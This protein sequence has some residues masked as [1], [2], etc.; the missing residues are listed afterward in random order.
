MACDILG[1]W[2]ID[3]I[4]AIDMSFKQTWKSVS[5]LE[6]DA[7]IPDMQKT[8]AKSAFVF[9]QGGRLLQLMPAGLA[10]EGERFDDDYAVVHEGKWKE[11]DGKIFASSEENG[12]D[13]WSEVVPLDGRIEVFGFF[14]LS[15]CGGSAPGC[16]DIDVAGVWIVKEAMVFDEDL[17]RTW[18]TKEAAMADGSADED[19]LKTFDT[20][21]VFSDDGFV[22][23]VV[24]IPEGVTQEQ[25]DQAV[26]SGQ[27]DLYG[28][29]FM[30]LEKHPWKIEDGKLMIDTGA[31]GEV[32]GE[33][34][35]PWTEA[36]VVDGVMQ[37]VAYR[38]IKE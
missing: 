20:K 19:A 11:E 1:M 14:R 10:G 18:K 36:P 34:V 29:R 30:A 9:E 21:F 5:E 28:D 26:T 27:I 38:L 24:P 15:K 37:Y 22:K 7:G 31:K 12:E 23:M 4:N 8:M 3:E 16:G 33:A 2:K 6:S 25:I 32:F 17:N 35:S 13:V